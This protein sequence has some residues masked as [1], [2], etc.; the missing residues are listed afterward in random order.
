VLLCVLACVCA[1][2][3]P[4]AGAGAG[5]GSTGFW[6]RRKEGNFCFGFA[7]KNDASPLTSFTTAAAAAAAELLPLPVTESGFAPGIGFT[8]LGNFAGGATGIGLAPAARATFFVGPGLL[9]GSLALRFRDA[10]ASAA[11]GRGRPNKTRPVSQARESGGARTKV[12]FRRVEQLP[13]CRLDLRSHIANRCRNQTNRRQ[14]ARLVLQYSLRAREFRER[15][16]TRMSTEQ[17]AR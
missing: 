9:A 8:P 5:G 11:V 17:G 12:L 1:C 13:P 7:E 14:P 3:D 4:G 6:I 2:T 10:L 15:T 16:T